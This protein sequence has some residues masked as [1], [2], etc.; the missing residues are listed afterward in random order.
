MAIYSKEQNSPIRRA[1]R[2]DMNWNI[3]IEIEKV[4]VDFGNEKAL[5]FKFTCGSEIWSRR[6]ESQLMHDEKARDS[7][8]IDMARQTSD[9]FI[10]PKL[11]HMMLNA[12]VTSALKGENPL[13]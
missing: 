1:D 12:L 7:I 2:D 8:L 10:T 6:V 13:E 5:N 11:V 9:K 4:R 3:H